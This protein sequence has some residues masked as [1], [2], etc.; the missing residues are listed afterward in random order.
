MG[1]LVGV[2][3]A[4]CV[5]AAPAA[6]ERRVGI[7]D[8]K[9]G[10]GSEE[11]VET[12]PEIALTLLQDASA[13]PLVAQPDASSSPM[14][15][16]P[17][18]SQM[19]ENIGKLVKDGHLGIEADLQQGSMPVMPKYTLEVQGAPKATVVV[20]AKDGKVTH[21]KFTVENGQLAVRGSG[22]RPKVAIESLEF[23]DPKGIDDLKFHGLGIWKPIVA[24]FGGIARSAVGKL[25]L[26]TDI[27][28][29]VK[30]EIFGAKKP[31]TVATPPP[32][33]TPTPPPAAGPPGGPPPSPTPSF[34]DLVR[35]V[36]LND[37]V[38]TAYGGRR[39]ALRPFVE[40]ETAPNPSGEAMK[41]SIPK[42]LFRPGHAG[43]PNYIELAGRLDGEI[44]NGEMEFE[45]NRVTISRGDIEDGEFEAKTGDDGKVA[46]TLSAA[47]LAF[48][49]S[50]GNFAVPGAM[51]VALDSGSK[52]EVDRLKVTSAGKF[53]G[54][55][56]LDLAGQTGELSRQGATLSASDIHLKTTGLT[57]V[58]GKATGPLEINFDYKLEYPFAVKY[59][60]KEIP[61]K[62]LD[63]DF[64]GP[65]AATLNLKD[66][67]ADSGEVTGNYLFKAPWDPIEQAA[68][69]VLEAKWQQDLAIKNID[70]TITPKM[71]RPCGETCFTLGIEV[72]AEKRTGKSKLKKLFSQF[73]AP[74]G[75][76]NLFIDKPE[77][78]FILKDVK[79][80]THCKG[81]VGWFVNFLTPFLTK[82][83]GDMK[84]FQMPPS[85]PLTVDSVRGGAHLVE[86][87]GSI[88]WT[89][90][91]GKPEV[92][93]KPQPV[94]VQPGK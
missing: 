88:D 86:I 9:A 17:S 55:A 63:L 70:F 45:A 49:L 89:A 2:F 72:T 5:A 48:E 28:S 40:F 22:L 20:E 13:S 83:Y 52:F 59:P 24:I 91:K 29:V 25:H 33:P 26:N 80:E 53:S 87:A 56:K 67:G 82:T 90:S 36:R 1:I 19:L 8:G 7:G 71:F 34:M 35:E 75:K 84:L 79:I 76:A 12:A 6:G 27:P 62:K 47:R 58:D 14:A 81:V 54:V 57:I 92:P 93:P 60:I 43:A 10:P 78:A 41:I 77:R 68:L 85:V 11:R 73:C 64:H 16:F 30:G 39:M 42:A 3:L 61:E 23:Q 32:A 4:G 66:A 51:G 15:A 69:V 50:S 31:E 18:T 74:V 46:S 44:V 94:E 38:V 21:M 37:M 65:F